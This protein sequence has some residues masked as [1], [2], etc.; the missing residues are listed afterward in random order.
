MSQAFNL[1][2]GTTTPTVGT[3]ATLDAETGAGVY[4]ITVNLKNMVNGDIV[5]LRAY[6]KVLTG[7]A[8]SWLAY[9]AEYSNLQGDAAAVGSKA[10]GEVLAISVP[11]VGAFGCT[12]TLLQTAGTARAFDWVVDQ[13]S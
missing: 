5:Q 12:F 3:E 9:K 10:N 13:L 7:D 6:K 2:H 11:I 1:A 8:Q 4:V